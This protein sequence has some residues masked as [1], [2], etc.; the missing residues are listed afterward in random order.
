MASTRRVQW[1]EG[2]GATRQRLD[3]LVALMGALAE[4]ARN[5]GG[6]R[7]SDAREMASLMIE[8]KRLESLLFKTAPPPEKKRAACSDDSQTG[9]EGGKK[10]K[11]KPSIP[12]K[13]KRIRKSAKPKVLAARRSGGAGVYG[14]GNSL[15]IWR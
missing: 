12:P 11:V 5:R 10:A 9:L 3:L 14:F 13:K 6:Y 4:N 7:Q 8:R 2:I 15:R 1:R